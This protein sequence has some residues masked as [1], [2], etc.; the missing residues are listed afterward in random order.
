MAINKLEQ[1]RELVGK[2][3]IITSAYRSPFHNARVGGA[4]RSF[5]K[6]GRAFDIRLK[7]HDKDHLFILA[8]AVGFGGVAARGNSFIHVDT[9]GKRTWKY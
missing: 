3:L 1:M 4:P 7:G 5:H 8:R 2:P 6:L 9:G